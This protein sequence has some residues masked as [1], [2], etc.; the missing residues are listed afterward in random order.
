M[1]WVHELAD[2]PRAL[3]TRN[4]TPGGPGCQASRDSTVICDM[5][6]AAAPL[7]L[8]PARSM[9]A[10]NGSKIFSATLPRAQHTS[11]S[12]WCARV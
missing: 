3:M 5:A 11:K 9:E 6:E 2:L 8:P 4:A 1:S 12:G 7:T 10:I